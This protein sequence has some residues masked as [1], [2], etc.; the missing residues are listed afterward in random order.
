MADIDL[1][2]YMGAYIDGSRENLDTMDRVLLSL[3]QNPNNLEA[4]EEIFRAAHTL[5]GMSATMGFE[6]VAH[7]THEMENLLDKLRTRQLPVTPAVIDVIFETFDVLRTLVNDTIAQTDSGVNLDEITGKL[8]AVLAGGGVL[9]GGE[10]A[11]PAPAPTESPAPTDAGPALEE[12]ASSAVP[13][14]GGASPAL[15]A[16]LTEMGL[17]EF[18]ISGMIEAQQ[19]GMQPYLLQVNMVADCLLKGPRIFMV[20][21]TLDASHCEIVK[22]IPEVK[23]LEN[24]KFDRSFKMIITTDQPAATVKDGIESISEIQEA[25]L[26]PLN[27]EALRTGNW[28]EAVIGGTEA[29]GAGAAPEPPPAPPPPPPAPPPTPAPRA[30]PR[31]APPPAPAPAA[32]TP[33]PAPRPATAARPAAAPAPSAPA[34]AAARPVA[35]APITHPQPAPPTP[36][37]PAEEPPPPP[38]P[39]EPPPES[40]D[41]T[42]PTEEEVQK[43]NIVQLVSFRMAGETYA[44]DIKKI[45]AII[46]LRPITRVPK[47]PAHIA[48]VINLRGEI[49]PVINLRKRL[50]LP[51]T[52][53]VPSMQI[54]ILVFEEE[55]VKVGF[56]VDTVSEVLR[57]PETSIEPPSH[58]SEG[59]DIEYLSGVGKIQNKIIILL[60]AE[61]IVFG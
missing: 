42:G 17:S 1:S 48:G 26:Y 45:E 61:K 21:R 11:A 37:P 23:D 2:E 50:K 49:V 58:V 32:P 39:G 30:A 3:E 56:L 33:A 15:I 8:H 7:L 14:G 60:N 51:E 54:I 6:K 53:L 46:N 19:N 20:L 34:A 43:E 18:E 57:L 40:P 28:A 27:P 31:P 36:A 22:S 44:L 59:V 29:A 4:V 55:K 41:E 16:D 13:A 25:L 38:P 47:A 10:T 12:S 24:E 35:P 9:P 52:E 5:K